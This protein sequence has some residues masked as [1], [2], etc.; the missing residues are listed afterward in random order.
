MIHLTGQRDGQTKTRSDGTRI[1]YFGLPGAEVHFN[2]MEPGVVQG[3]HAHTAI[4][5][6][7]AIVS[8][9]L[10]VEYVEEGELCTVQ[11]H[12]GDV[13]AVGSDIHRVS[14]SP[15]ERCDFLVFR[16]ARG[17]RDS[18]DLPSDKKTYSD[19]EIRALTGG[20]K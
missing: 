19:S 2:S 6:I 10:S 13:V 8:G 15:S 18:A 12:S 9:A 20:G 1:T 3:W 14:C 17:G 7:I 11:G 4:D 5:E 16:V